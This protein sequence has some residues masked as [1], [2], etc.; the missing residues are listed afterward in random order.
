[1]NATVKWIVMYFMAICLL[2][3]PN[4]AIRAEGEPAEG[5]PPAAV[6]KKIAVV[7]DDMGNDMAG[8]KEM[9]EL[10]I[11]FT[12]AVMPFLPTTK[13]DAEWAHQLGHD[14]LLHMPME[15]VKGKKSWLGPGAITTDL[16]DDEIRRRMLAAIEEVPFA[17]G[18]NNHMGSKV[19]ADPRVMRIVLEVCKEK[20]LFYLDSKTTSKSVVQQTAKEVGVRTLENN[21][22]MDDVYTRDHI[23]KQALKVQKYVDGHDTTVVIGHVG[24][25]GKYTASVLKESVPSLQQRAQFV[26]VS[27]LVQ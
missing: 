23:A 6:Q 26:K 22:F 17:V 3:G 10:P 11:P 21:I 1:M 9:M 19:T 20:H 14:V 25:P 7:I 13:R 27:Q 15:P 4:G 2:L 24:P 8:T 5:S 16:S 18:I 12:V